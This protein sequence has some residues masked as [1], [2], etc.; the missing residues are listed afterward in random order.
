MRT[1]DARGRRIG[2][3]AATAVPLRLDARAECI[4]GQRFDENK[5]R[6]AVK[7]A[8]ADVEAMADLHASA[9]YRKRV[10]RRSAVRAID[11]PKDAARRS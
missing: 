6:E 3:G 9:D 7:A 2:I 11:D 4:A 1:A 10:A 8:L 5:V